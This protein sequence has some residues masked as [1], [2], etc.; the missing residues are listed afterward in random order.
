[1]AET[2][3]ACGA[4]AVTIEN[5][6]GEQRLQNALE[7]AALWSANRIAGL[8]GEETNVESVRE[9]LQRSLGYDPGTPTVERLPDAD[10]ARVWMEHYE[11]VKI[12]PRLWICPSWRTPP[13][14]TATNILL[15]PGL[16]FGTGTHP[17]TALCLRWLEEQDCA[18]QTIIDYG[19][20]SGI[21]AIAALKRGATRAIGIDVDPQALTASRDNAARNGIGARYES[22][23]PPELG[24]DV[25]ADVV[26]ANI[27]AG[28]LIEL[29][30]ELTRRVKK[31][32]LLALSG[33][34]TAQAPEVCVHYA[35]H[36]R[37]HCEEQDGWMLIAGSKLS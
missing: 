7:E 31:N 35:R 28:T 20:G 17:T 10:W 32:G 27:L 3:E 33:V 18:G 13:D 36:F 24:S 23:L 21:L 5:E 2:L 25:S 29:A 22:C 8:F 11:P 34:L 1:M 9:Q 14:P 30:P 37:L 19:C 4:A 15:D 16:A 26:L 12:A 6:S